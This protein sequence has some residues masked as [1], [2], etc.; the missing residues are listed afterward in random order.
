MMLLDTNVLSEFMRPQ[1]AA[2]VVAWLDAQNPANTYT[3]A[4]ARAEIELG[5]ALM[6]AG[7]RQA[8]LTHAA[9]TMFDTELQGRCLPF[10]EAAAS[11]YAQTVANRTRMGRPISTEDAQIAAIALAHGLTLATRNTADF[12]HISRLVVVNPWEFEG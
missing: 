2:Q 12:E 9:Q 5:L 8:G 3:S 6:P 11:H 4:I 10:D 1:P 7:Q